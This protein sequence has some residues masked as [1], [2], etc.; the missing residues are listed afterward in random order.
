MK[1][2]I[3]IIIVAL[4]VYPFLNLSAQNKGA[5]NTKSISITYKTIVNGKESDQGGK[6]SLLFK[7]DQVKIK[8]LHNEIINTKLDIP[9]ETMF[10]DFK[11]N[12]T[13]QVADFKSGK[14]ITVETSFNTLPQFELTNE[15]AIIAGF[16]CKKAQTVIRSNK[17][18]VWYTEKA[19]VIGSPMINLIIPNA[20]IV[21][22]VRNGNFET[23]IDKIE[24]L[25]TSNTLPFFPSSWGEIVDAVTYRATI[26][27]NYITTISVFDREQISFGNEIK[28]PTDANSNQTFKFSNG[29]VLLRK[30]I[31]PDAKTDYS[32]FA[33]LVQYSNGDA[34]D[35]TGSVFII[36]TDRPVS[37][38]KALQNGL[39]VLPIYKDRQGKA[40][41]GM[42]AT[43]DFT[44]LIELMRFFTPFGIRHYNNQVKVQGLK[45]E[46][47]T[48]YKQDVTPI[49]SK[50]KGE[51]WVGVFIGN[52][53]R[54]GHI[55]SLKLKYYPNEQAEKEKTQTKT[56]I[57]PL[58]NTVNIMEMS[59]QEYGTMF[60]QDSLRVDFTI[61]KGL[62]NI[63][64]QYIS[65]GHGGWDG[66]DEFNPKTNQ[67]IIDEKPVYSYIPWRS[68]CATFRKYNPAS[69]NFWN[70]I[71]SSDLSR[72]GWCPGTLT[73]PVFIPLNSLQPGNHTMKI[74][75]P[76]GKREGGSFSAWCVSGVLIG[77][78]E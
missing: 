65:T 4:L 7:N 19:G 39:A 67:I 9:T 49:L 10:I 74:A 78:F 2:N 50:L 26:T 22:I 72:S 35:R 63:Q 21:K 52:Y 30:I 48:Y 27:E 76:L 58:F 55:A 51:A 14:R 60:D 69:G 46:D 71:S 12:K 3:Y 13:Y 44:P 68:D 43:N 73:N 16:E 5:E 77:E 70:G 41:Q 32:A 75:I 66:G 28:N 54:G 17:I 29:T 1:R 11:A 61:P 15:K 42:V 8:S 40:Y 33:E 57:S 25:K 59:G 47:S 45:W 34:Y 38:L 20:L 53:D 36:P 56:W 6:T 37:F 62:K 24:P 18:E 23:V 31:L 64:L